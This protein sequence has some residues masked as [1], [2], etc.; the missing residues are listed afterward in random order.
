MSLDAHLKRHAEYYSKNY[1]KVADLQYPIH[2]KEFWQKKISIPGL[3]L[4]HLIQVAE[5]ALLSHQFGVKI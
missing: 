5:S 4:V 3:A 2:F 1:S